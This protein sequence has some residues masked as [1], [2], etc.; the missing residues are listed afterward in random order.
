MS[1]YQEIVIQTYEASGTSSNKP[2]RAR[3]VAGQG[4]SIKLNVECSTK[5]RE[6]YP[7]G[8]FMIVR[9]KITDVEGTPFVYTHYNWPYKVVTEAEATS[10]IRN[11]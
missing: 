1:F 7:V 11:R 2:I 10:F 3:P 4:L 6:A 8:T 9:A 5:M